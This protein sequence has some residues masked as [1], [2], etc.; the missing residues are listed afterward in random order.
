MDLY[1]YIAA[2]SEQAWAQLAD[3]TQQI[4]RDRN[5]GDSARTNWTSS[6]KRFPARRNFWSIKRK[7]IGMWSPWKGIGCC[8]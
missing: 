5:I 2:G 6:G 4:T 7:K 1:Y 3:L 8:G